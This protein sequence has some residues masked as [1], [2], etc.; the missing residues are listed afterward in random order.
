MPIIINVISAI[1]SIFSLLSKYLSVAAITG[2][3]SR[4]IAYFF[5][6]NGLSILAGLSLGYSSYVG[7]DVLVDLAISQ[8][9][10]TVSAV[11]SQSQVVVGNTGQAF[12]WAGYMLKLASYAGLFDALEIVIAGFLV[13]NSMS[14]FKLILNRVM[15]N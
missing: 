10:Q 14:T 1:F 3:I 2:L 4:G 13:A 11:D 12:N 9:T 7:I 5:T 15:P 8:I 6:A